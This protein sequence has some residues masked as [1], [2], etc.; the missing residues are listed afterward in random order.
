MGYKYLSILSMVYVTI[1]ITTVILIYNLI[2]V[3][4][5]TVSISTLI[6]PLW[7]F[8]GDVIAE[9]YGYQKAR[10]L[11]WGAIFCQ[12]LFAFICFLVVSLNPGQNGAAFQLVLGSVPRVAI[13]SSFAIMAGAFVN[14]YIITK[15]K[16]ILCGRY[17]WLRSLGA[18]TLGELIFTC[19]AFI[20]EF[21]GVV[22]FPEIIQLILASYCLKLL[23]NPIFLMP[24]MTLSNFLKKSEGI[25]IYDTH[26]N[27]NP[28][29]LSANDGRAA[30]ADIGRLR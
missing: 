23:V 19:V 7:F 22:S 29:I 2:Q 3:A 8:V 20:W 27:F 14:A 13:A 16:V 10:Q 5:F 17:F 4:G 25:D 12:I 18:T 21:I 24:A 30:M 26:T 6:M 28:F 9:T 15:W 1:K 11:I